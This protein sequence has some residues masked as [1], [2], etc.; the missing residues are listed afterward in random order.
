KRYRLLVPRGRGRA[1]DRAGIHNARKI[2]STQLQSCEPDDADLRDLRTADL[3]CEAVTGP[4][5]HG[6]ARR[7]PPVRWLRQC[8]GGSSSHLLKLRLRLRGRRR[9]R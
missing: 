9:A 3:L 7:E 5:S 8:E 1:K 6:L 2:A 4:L